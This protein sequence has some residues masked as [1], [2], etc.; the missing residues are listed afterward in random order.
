MFA[1]GLIRP[2]SV[3]ELD[4]TFVA[5]STFGIGSPGSKYNVD[6]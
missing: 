1:S 4:E 3:T 6:P 5:A 2:F